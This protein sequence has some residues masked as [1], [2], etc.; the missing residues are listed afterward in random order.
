MAEENTQEDAKMGIKKATA[1]P[2][3]CGKVKSSQREHEQFP[4]LSISKQWQPR[5]LQKIILEIPAP[6]IF[7]FVLAFL[8]LLRRHPLRNHCSVRITGLK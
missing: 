7:A 3:L 8:I 5:D 2:Q 4:S 1:E 6:K